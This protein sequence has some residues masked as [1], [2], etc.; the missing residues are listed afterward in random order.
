M[1][2]GLREATAATTTGPVTT[3]AQ[4]V[5]ATALETVAIIPAIT[6]VTTLVAAPTATAGTV[7]GSAQT[8]E[9][10]EEVVEAAAVVEEDITPPGTSVCTR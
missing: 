2:E 8:G 1:I 7:K 6:M 4:V 3:V 9:A 5:M 10:E